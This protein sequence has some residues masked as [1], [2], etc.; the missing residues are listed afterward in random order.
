MGFC[1]FV[2]NVRVHVDFPTL[3]VPFDA[4]PPD[5][6]SVGAQLSVA[7]IWSQATH[8]PS[9]PPLRLHLLHQII[10]I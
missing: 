7:P 10:L 3:E 6:V 9:P 1:T 2:S 8:P 4:L 5:H